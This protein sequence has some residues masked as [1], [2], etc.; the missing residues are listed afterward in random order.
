LTAAQLPRASFSKRAATYFS[1]YFH[2][3]H[4]GR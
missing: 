2:E 3:K 1:G 4:C